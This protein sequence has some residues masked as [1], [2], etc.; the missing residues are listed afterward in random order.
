MRE[1]LN[2][3]CPCRHVIKHPEFLARDEG[4][5]MAYALFKRDGWE[6]AGYCLWYIPD[7]LKSRYHFD[8]M[9]FVESAVAGGD[10]T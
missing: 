4:E 2:E 3:V 8:G 6:D 5:L 10:Q 9:V 1:P 7:H